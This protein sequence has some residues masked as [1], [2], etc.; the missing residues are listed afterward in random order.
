ME[1]KILG[2]LT[3]LMC[4]C[5]ALNLRSRYR[6]RLLVV[7]PYFHLH[8]SLISILGARGCIEIGITHAIVHEQARQTCGMR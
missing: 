6:A 3:L 5:C 8:V 4:A 1:C 2:I 7:M